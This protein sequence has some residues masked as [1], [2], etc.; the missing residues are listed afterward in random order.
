MI[1][2]PR[3]SEVNS[4]S[5]AKPWWNRPLIGN[6]S[7]VDRCKSV[8]FRK[9]VEKESIEFHQKTFAKIT[10]LSNRMLSL[11]QEKFGN[12]EFLT[13]VRINL[14]L[15]RG[16]G[17]YQH[18]LAPKDL[19]RAGLTAHHSFSSLEQIEF[20]HRGRTF[21]EF[22]DF[23]ESLCVKRVHSEVFC[24]QVT[25]KSPEVFRSLI[26]SEGKEAL[27]RY[28]FHLEKIGKNQLSLSLLYAFKRLQ[29]RNYNIFQ[30]VSDILNALERSDLLNLNALK[31]RVIQE[32]ESFEKLGA[33]INLREEQR[34]IQTYTLL[35]QYLAMSERHER[36]YDQF[37]GLSAQLKTWS[38]LTKT[39]IQIRRQYPSSEYK[40]P[41]QFRAKVAGIRLYEKYSPYFDELE[42]FG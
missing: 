17:N 28:T 1:V 23:V 40:L 20:T 11:D 35:F 38:Q 6:K 36:A 8:L 31:T 2:E 34:N 27:R 21:S 37:I 12:E 32:Y 42:A 5:K 18:L 24:R 29:F 15:Q 16:E 22:Y 3:S 19:L 9:I 14:S 26:S 30:I 25:A 13:F 7:L 41:K 39:L 4:L 10:R 33:L